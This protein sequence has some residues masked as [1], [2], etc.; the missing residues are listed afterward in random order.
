MPDTAD[1]TPSGVRLADLIAR[2]PLSRGSVF[3]LIKALG[4]TTEKGP[5]PDGMGRVAW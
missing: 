1:A 5:G 3:E 2:S 4:I